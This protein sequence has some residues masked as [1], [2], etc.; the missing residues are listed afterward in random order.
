MIIGD[1]LE[2]SSVS[3]VEPLFA[4]GSAIKDAIVCN[5]LERSL[6]QVHQKVEVLWSKDEK[7]YPGT[8][9]PID[10]ATQKRHILYDNDDLEFLDHNN[11]KGRLVLKQLSIVFSTYLMFHYLK[12]ESRRIR[13]VTPTS[14]FTL[15]VMLKR[16]TKEERLA[17]QMTSSGIEENRIRIV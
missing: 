13:F 6:P 5:E 15:V 16:T 9:G 4:E 8:T 10:K 7:Y 2:I 1:I 12:T 3:A 11:K 14:T 17:K